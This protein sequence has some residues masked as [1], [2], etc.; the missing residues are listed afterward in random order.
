LNHNG[1][2]MNNATAM[3]LAIART[4]RQV[5]ERHQRTRG[6][7]GVSVAAVARAAGMT[8]I[9]AVTTSS[10]RA[11]NS[12]SRSS[13]SASGL[14]GRTFPPAD[15][16]VESI[17]VIVIASASL[18]EVGNVVVTSGRGV[19]EP[20]SPRVLLTSHTADA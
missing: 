1:A 14:G 18:T 19:I 7:A 11:M 17:P 6:R 4:S 5:S 13:V 3:K 15:W 2:V 9:G 8:E 16:P 12:A 20:I 10:S